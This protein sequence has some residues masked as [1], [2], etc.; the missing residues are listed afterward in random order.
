M[1][2]A[3]SS[4]DIRP[5]LAVTVDEDIDAGDLREVAWSVASR[6]HAERDTG[7]LSEF[8][9]LADGGGETGLKWYIDSAMPALT[10]SEGRTVFERAVPKNLDLIHL[11]EFL[12]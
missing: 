12:P 7:I 11:A 2:A 6:V 1:L 4:P 5:R 9:Q 10:Q 3:L 8:P